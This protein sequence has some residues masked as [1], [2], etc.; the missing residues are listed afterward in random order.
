MKKY[1]G[2]VITFFLTIIL[3][4]TIFY[5]SG[6][7]DKTILISDL[8]SEYRPLLKSIGSGELGLYNFSTTMGDNVI[9]TIFYYMA[10]PL[11][12]LSFVIKDVNLLVIV[13]VTIKLALAAVFAYLFFVYQFKEKKESYLISFA[14][15]YALSSFS[16]SYYLH[17]MWLDSYLLLPLVLLG[18][19]KMIREKKILLYCLALWLTIFTN[20]YFSYMI[21]IFSFLYFNYRIISAK[22]KII[23]ENI[24]FIITTL[25]TILCASV[26]LLPIIGEITSYSRPNG[27]LFGGS[28]ISFDFNVVN[29]FKTLILG[30]VS[31]IELLN[32]KDF[33]LYTSTIIVP[34][35][36]LYFINKKIK[37]RE[38]LLTAGMLLILILSI[39]CNYANIMWH[40]FVLPSYFN[41]RFTFLFILFIL[42]V[43]LKA[44]YYQQHIPFYH[45][46][47]AGLIVIIPTIILTKDI[48]SFLKI[49]AV[50]VALVMLKLNFRLLFLGTIIVELTIN[51]YL[52]LNRYNFQTQNQVDYP[53]KNS[54][55]YL[56][57]YDD[58]AFYRIED[59]DPNSSN[60]SLLYD[61]YGV[62]YFMSTIKK[63]LVEFF[64]KMDMNSHAYT[65]NTISYDGSNLLLSSLLNIKY[66]L[67]TNNH[68]NKYY[69]L[70]V[71]DNNSIKVYYNP[72]YLN[73]GYMVDSN[74]TNLKLSYD[75]LANIQALYKA[76][77][78]EDILEKIDIE[79]IDDNNYLLDNTKHDDIY[80][81]INYKGW[82]YYEDIVVSFDD[83]FLDS[84]SHNYLY[85]ID[86]NYDLKKIPINISNG[87]SEDLIDVSAYYLNMD[88]FK[89]AIDK[90]RQSELE[91]SKVK[92]SSLEG[93]IDVL[94][95]GVLFTSIPYDKG[96]DVYVD[97]KKVSKIK[98]LDTFIG[99]NLKQGQHHIKFVYRPKLL[100]LSIIP[101]LIGIILLFIYQRK[102]LLMYKKK[103]LD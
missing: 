39:I 87:S 17:I 28:K 52:Y 15:L 84:S 38:K 26:I 100:Y 75:G 76:M 43:T 49:F 56:K 91:V 64:V 94:N 70:L 22:K 93:E 81:L 60:Y 48:F 37:G 101:S 45:Y 96:I 92:K 4:L 9:G 6:I 69:N 34:L 77:S 8:N 98:L 59:D 57:S 80:L 51:G 31:S 82:Y 79:K 3:T 53:I 32:S 62:D 66:Y 78:N 90:L 44:I 5:L 71:D 10:S 102:K 89:K 55:K 19:D 29:Y 21:V 12:L 14:L 95:D 58:S 24:H 50:V 18:I 83:H 99:V 86:N 68:Q 25:L 46:L 61:Y 73:L 1:R 13:I 23:K 30:D 20:Y 2:I 11:N 40:G 88:N 7:F 72:Y 74:I 103:D 42:L 97:G 27:A 36:Y 67:E 65:K 35:L 16:I 41:G 63:D 85:Q 54:I 33:Y 47:I